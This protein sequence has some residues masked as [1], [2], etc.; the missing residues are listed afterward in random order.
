MESFHAGSASGAGSYRCVSCGF[1]VMLRNTDEMPACPSCGGQSFGRA[2]LFRSSGETTEV[3]QAPELEE[4]PAWLPSARASI[5]EGL[6]LA[7]EGRTGVE[8]VELSEGWTRIG[9]SIS[10]DVRIDD[11]TV[12]RRHALVHHQ[13]GGAKVLDDRSLNGVF[14]NGEQVDLAE[15]HDG[16]TL[17]VGRFQLH[18]LMPTGDREA[19]AVG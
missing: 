4:P 17:A 5:G 1:E 6:H 14:L 19:L 10:A 12:S 16:D 15:L 13:D 9:R 2:P 18:V 7:F 3:P 11:P 8:V